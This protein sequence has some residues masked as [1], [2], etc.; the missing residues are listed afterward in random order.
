MLCIVF[1][2]HKNKH[3]IQSKREKGRLIKCCRKETDINYKQ[4]SMCLTAC[5][6]IPQNTQPHYYYLCIS[7]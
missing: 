2:K 3:E 7:K 6:V 5:F 4:Q 1:F